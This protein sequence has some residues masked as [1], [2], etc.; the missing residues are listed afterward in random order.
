MVAG[1][2]AIGGDGEAIGPARLHRHR[3]V[4]ALGRERNDGGA[5]GQRAAR[6]EGA[7]DKG[8]D[9]MDVVGADPQLLRQAVLEAIDV[10]AGLPKCQLRPLPSAGRREQLDGI[11]VLD[12]GL[13]AGVDLHRRGGEDRLR[14]A[15]L[16]VL[17]PLAALAAPAALLGGV[18][19]CDGRGSRAVEVARGRLLGIGDLQPV[20]RFLR[21]G[22]G[23]GDHQGHDLAVVLD[24]VAG[25]RSDG[26]A[27]VALL[28]EGLAGIDQ[29]ADV[30]VGQDVH[31]SGDSAGGGLVDGGDPAARDG[32]G[33]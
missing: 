4:Q 12:R 14:V 27:H 3:P 31:H 25:E 33:A 28:V 18:L 7:A 15:D 29:L 9:D 2:G 30:S 8:R 16:G 26:S 6:A 21:V 5:L 17:V 32:A 19:G 22:S 24:A 11:M 13:V 1:G 23:V 20:R 10:L